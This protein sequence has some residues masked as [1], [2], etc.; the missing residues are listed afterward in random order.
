MNIN[1]KVPFSNHHR[2]TRYLN[3][4]YYYYLFI[5]TTKSRAHEMKIVLNFHFILPNENKGY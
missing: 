4:Y 1:I 5:D 2:I 3:K